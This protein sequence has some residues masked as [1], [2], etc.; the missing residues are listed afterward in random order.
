MTKQAFLDF[1]RDA[2]GTVPDY[3]F[4]EDLETAVLLPDVPDGVVQFLASVSYEATRG[5]KPRK[6]SA[7]ADPRFESETEE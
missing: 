3:P 4:E 6:K 7:E 5:K 2:F 1:C